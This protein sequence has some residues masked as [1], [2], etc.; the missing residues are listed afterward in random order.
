MRTLSTLTAAAVI[1]LGVGY[2]STA[3]ASHALVN[4]GAEAALGAEWSTTGGAVRD[5]N[6]SG[7]T[8]QA[9]EL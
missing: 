8:P 4:G 1:A 5:S 2:A 6:A 3:Q 7:I 9:G